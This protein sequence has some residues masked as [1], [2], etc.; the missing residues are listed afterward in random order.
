MREIIFVR[1]L[2]TGGVGSN[3]FCSFQNLHNK[4]AA[5]PPHWIS[6]S[7]SVEIK[8]PTT[9]LWF[10]RGACPMSESAGSG[11]LYFLI[12]LGFFVIAVSFLYSICRSG[13]SSH[14]PGVLIKSSAPA[15][16]RP[17][18]RLGVHSSCW[19]TDIQPAQS[20]RPDHASK[21]HERRGGAQQDEPRDGGIRKPSASV[22]FCRADDRLRGDR[23]HSWRRP[24]EVGSR[25]EYMS[26][27][28]RWNWRSN[29]RGACSHRG[30]HRAAWLSGWSARLVR[31]RRPHRPAGL[32]MGKRIMYS[33]L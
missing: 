13:D 1:G 10:D 5:Y 19:A 29:G 7:R 6:L 11:V 21:E 28:V 27:W 33:I 17:S 3:S 30:N 24:A 25:L 26:E 16:L 22:F 31:W 20:L 9:V 2:L 23:M 8:S 18:R 14:S 12:A 15:R 32:T 4:Y